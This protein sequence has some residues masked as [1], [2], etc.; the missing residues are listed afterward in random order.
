[1]NV[2]TA[3]RSGV[4]GRGAPRAANKAAGT[5]PE[6]RGGQAKIK[7]ISTPVRIKISRFPK[8]FEK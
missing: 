1:M 6:M 7:L 2:L 4:F 3:V 8:N 5:V